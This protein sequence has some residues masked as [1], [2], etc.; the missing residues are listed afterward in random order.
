MS[1]LLSDS[2]VTV[3]WDDASSGGSVDSDF[4]ERDACDS[5]K[6]MASFSITIIGGGL[7]LSACNMT[8]LRQYLVI[9]VCC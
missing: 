3:E 8:M 7:E 9:E 5:S 1:S 2:G 4:S 6:G